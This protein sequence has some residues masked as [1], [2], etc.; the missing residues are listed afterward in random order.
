LVIVGRTAS[1]LEELPIF[2]EN[3]S[4]DCPMGLI[5]KPQERIDAKIVE[6]K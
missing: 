2:G 4:T 3:R 1:L 5:N 6:S